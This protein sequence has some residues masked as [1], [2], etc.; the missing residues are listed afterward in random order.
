MHI[1]WME[2]LLLLGILIVAIWIGAPLWNKYIA[3]SSP[4]LAI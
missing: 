3:A 4:S 2:A 1:D